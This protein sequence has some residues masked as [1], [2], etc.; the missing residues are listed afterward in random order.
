MEITTTTNDTTTTIA[1]DGWLDTGTAPA[2]SSAIDQLGPECQKL[3]LD[4]T[5]LEYI[6]S[7]GLRMLVA[8]HKKVHGNL[9]ITNASPEV[10]Q[11]LHMTGLDKRL[12][13]A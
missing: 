2:L 7:A 5:K 10:M 3:V 1:L 4:F 9:T 8:A 11:V 6:S 12:N 13:V